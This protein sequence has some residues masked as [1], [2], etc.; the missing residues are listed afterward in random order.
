MNTENTH[1]LLLIVQSFLFSL[2]PD[3][4]L[5]TGNL[6]ISTVSKKQRLNYD[7]L[8]SD[9]KRIQT[10]SCICQGTHPVCSSAWKGS[11]QCADEVGTYGHKGDDVLDALLKLGSNPDYETRAELVWPQSSSLSSSTTSLVAGASPPNPRRDS[12]SEDPALA[13]PTIRSGH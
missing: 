1:G 7:R 12:G 5:F 11:G 10:T 4:N 13:F 3:K 6:N 2:H 8:G 9:T